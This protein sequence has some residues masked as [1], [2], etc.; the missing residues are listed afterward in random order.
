MK[1]KRVLWLLGMAAL[2]IVLYTIV[3]SRTQNTTD[4][5][6]GGAE[7]AYIQSDSTSYANINLIQEPETEPEP[8]I[9]PQIDITMPQYRM[10]RDQKNFLLLSSFTPELE[11]ASVGYD[12]YFDAAEI[13]HLE[14]LIAALKEEGY[15]FSISTAYMSYSYLYQRFNGTASGIAEG[16]GV[17]DYND[18]DYQLAVAE[19]KK[20]LMF[21]GSSEH[22]L[23]LAIDIFDSGSVQYNLQYLN[24]DFYNWMNE[25]CAE[26]GFIQ[27]YPTRKYLLTGWDEPWHY[28]YVGV[29]AA[30]FIMEQGICYEEFYQHYVPEFKY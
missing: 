29:E 27:R 25:H 12:V 5:I 20:K 24:K 23:G 9:W 14:D 2:C 28:R 13:Q 7:G 26:Y 6:F 30:T 3:V 17:T 1:R 10:V 16:M 4:I 8:D 18:P 22:Q 21:P 19:A 11:K 15:S